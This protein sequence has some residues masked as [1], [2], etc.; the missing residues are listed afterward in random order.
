MGDFLSFTSCLLNDVVLKFQ[1]YLSLFF[2]CNDITLC[3]QYYYYNSVYPKKHVRIPQEDHSAIVD[4][5]LRGSDYNQS[6]DTSPYTTQSI[7]I[8]NTK[9]DGNTTRGES[10]K[11]NPITDF[12]SSSGSP[13]GSYSS[14]SNSP[15]KK[16]S[17]V[18]LAVAATALNITSANAFPIGD[19]SSTAPSSS[20]FSR[21]TLGFILAWSCTCVYVAS[22]CP[23]LYKNYQRKSVDGIS[24]LLFGSALLGNLTY[25]LSIVTSCSFLFSDTKSTFIMKELPYILGSSGTILFDVAYF[26]QR[27][28]YRFNGRNTLEME[29]EEETWYQDR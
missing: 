1:V 20:L 18:G 4:V 23:Q 24:P 10:N 29:L 13:D 21:E 27:Y 2:I 17:R 26:Y 14:T 16:S 25:T 8:H 6:T 7:H 3:Y 9:H 15:S 22:R 12:L 19:I 28:L 11:D 5:E